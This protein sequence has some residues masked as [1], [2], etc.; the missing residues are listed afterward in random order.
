[1]GY[2]I[3]QMFKMDLAFI[4]IYLSN[5]SQGHEI[6]RGC[7]MVLR[8]HQRMQNVPSKVDLQLTD[9]DLSMPM[10]FK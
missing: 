10:V 9:G 4:S 1:M 3:R 6:G 7:L 5:P 8:Y 2:T